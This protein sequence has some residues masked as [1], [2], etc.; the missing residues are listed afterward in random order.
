MVH[1]LRFFP[2]QNAVCFIILTYLV[3]LL[4]T[5]YIQGVLKFKKNNSGA[6]KLITF[7]QRRFK[8]SSIKRLSLRLL[9]LQDVG[10]TFLPN[11]IFTIPRRVTWQKTRIFITTEITLNLVSINH[12]VRHSCCVYNKLDWS[13]CTCLTQLYD[14]R[15]VYIFHYIQ[16]NYMFRPFFIGHLQV[17]K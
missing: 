17:Y 2:L 8:S 13:V 5:F 4:F 9:D 14:G 1:T 11:I 6:K 12:K 15:D 7:V 10:S 16:N 3:P